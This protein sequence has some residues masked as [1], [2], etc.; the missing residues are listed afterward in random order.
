VGANGWN[1]RISND[2]AVKQRFGQLSFALNEG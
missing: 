1:D 2:L